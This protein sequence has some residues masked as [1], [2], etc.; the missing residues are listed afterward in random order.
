MARGKVFRGEIREDGKP[1]RGL[2]LQMEN[3][4][5]IFLSEGEGDRLGTLAVAIPQRKPVGPALS[6]AL[7]GDRNVLVAR[8]LAERVAQR[9]GKIALV[10]VY[11]KTVSEREAS[12]AFV[13]LLERI[14]G[15]GG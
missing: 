13:K 15:E 6:S 5:L 14:V 12:S 8:M 9:T 11:V 4:N 10:S 7:L 2:C 1:F 3:A